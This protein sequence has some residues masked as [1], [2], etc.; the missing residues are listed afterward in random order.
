MRTAL[1][2]G[3]WSFECVA[4]LDKDGVDDDGEVEACGVS[5]LEELLSVS[6]L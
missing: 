5:S 2:S 1:P 4:G 6:A 3:S